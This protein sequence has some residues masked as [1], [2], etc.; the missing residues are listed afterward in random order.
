[1][2][3]PPSNSASKATVGSIFSIAGTVAAQPQ[4]HENWDA[5]RSQDLLDIGTED[6]AIGRTVNNPRGASV[7]SWRGAA[8]KV[9]VFQCPKGASPDSRFSLRPQVPE[10][11]HVGLEPSL[12]AVAVRLGI[13]DD[14]IDPPAAQLRLDPLHP[15][16]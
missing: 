6:I 4:C 13:G 14:E 15:G 1:M 7:R 3:S 12:V 10:R 8:M 11:R 9:D 16:P 5:P 2:P